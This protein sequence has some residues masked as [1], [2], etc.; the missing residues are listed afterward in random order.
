MKKDLGISTG[1][2]ISGTEALRIFFSKSI[3]AALPPIWP[4][5]G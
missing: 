3:P 4:A 5:P 2:T 1:W